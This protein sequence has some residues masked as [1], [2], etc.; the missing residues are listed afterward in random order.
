MPELIQ[1]PDQTVYRCVYCATMILPSDVVLKGGCRK[2]GSKRMRVAA[3]V[4]DEEAVRAIGEG[5]VFSEER[6]D[7]GPFQGFT[8]E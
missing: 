7:E 3:T 8:D 2:C 4:S 1:E 5:Y 6:W